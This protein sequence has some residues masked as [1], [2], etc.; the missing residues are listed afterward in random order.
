MILSSV[1]NFSPAKRSALKFVFNNL[2]HLS[3]VLASDVFRPTNP[4]QT[5]PDSWP[6][7][8][9]YH[10]PEVLQSLENISHLSLDLRVQRKAS[11]HFQSFHYHDDVA[12]LF[13]N[14]PVTFQRLTSLSLTHFQSCGS[15]LLSLLQRHRTIRALTL[16]HV[17]EIMDLSELHSWGSTQLPGDWVA[18]AGWIEVVDVMRALRLQRLDLSGLEGTGT[19]YLLAGSENTNLRLARVY[20]YVLHGYGPNPLGPD[21]RDVENW[22]AELWGEN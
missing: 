6:S 8:Y 20:D 22:D 10:L 1:F 9:W 13:Q 18:A 7:F 2:T 17:I 15:S 14:Q 21:Q 4:H 11:F 3:L 16:R 12:E 5:S 19:N